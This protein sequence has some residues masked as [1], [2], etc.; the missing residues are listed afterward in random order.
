MA[1]ARNIKPGFFTNA[2]LVDCSPL[3]R[4][5]FIGLWT[6]S[7]RRGV[8]EDHPKNL[9]IRLL[10]GDNCDVN[11]LLDELVAHG[12]VERYEAAGVRCLYIPGFAKHQYPHQGE[13]PSTLPA[14]DSAPPQT[15]KTPDKHH[16]GDHSSAPEP[17]T[18]TGPAPVKHHAGTGQPPDD[19]DTSP[20]LTL[21]LTESIT[22]SITESMESARVDALD[23]A[24][25]PPP[26][27]DVSDGE[28]S[29]PPTK[30]KQRLPG[31]FV[32]SAALRTWA[33]TALQFDGATIDR[34]TE[35]FCDHFRASGA[36]KLDWVAAW[37][38][39]MRGA[40]EGKFG[41]PVASGPPP[42]L[43]RDRRPIATTDAE[44]EAG[45]ARFLGTA[46]SRGA[47]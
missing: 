39:W 22:E 19:H 5:L 3:A 2:D 4:L 33:S 10:P 47:S 32:P 46:G 29:N 13:R 25:A 28:A 36:V 34:E 8:L 43:P 38:N 6:E 26:P 12:F 31:D 1:R 23:G 11:Q 41:R 40:A 21:T 45:V 24:D 17:D 44:L 42:P 9:K 37:R 20:A 27:Q 14:P 16:A 30:R 7:D 15:T 18:G 35:K